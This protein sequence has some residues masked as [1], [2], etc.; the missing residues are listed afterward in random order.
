MPETHQFLPFAF[1][2]FSFLSVCAVRLLDIVLVEMEVDVLQEG[3]AASFLS[4]SLASSS[5]SQSLSS[6][7]VNPILNM[8]ELEQSLSYY[9]KNL[10]EIGGHIPVEKEEEGDGGQFLHI[11]SK[12]FRF[13]ET[14][15]IIIFPFLIFSLL[16]APKFSAPSATPTKPPTTHFPFAAATP[17]ADVASRSTYI[18]P[19]S[20]G[21]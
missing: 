11:F 14:S 21:R 9:Y 4:T 8:E 15:P 18:S 16:Q 5:S 10:R 13:F 19:C 7:A 17:T 1:E 3:V 12:Y 6:P 2:L 20:R